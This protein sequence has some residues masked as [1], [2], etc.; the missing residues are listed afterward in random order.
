MCKETRSIVLIQRLIWSYKRKVRSSMES[1]DEN[2]G[3]PTAQDVT[4]TFIA[5]PSTL[6]AR[7]IH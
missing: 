3:L 7:D 2:N 5:L 6:S 4:L 1:V